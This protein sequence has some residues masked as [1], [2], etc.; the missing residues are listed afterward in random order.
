MTIGARARGMP[1]PSGAALGASHPALLVAEYRARRGGPSTFEQRKK[2]GTLN[3]RA[4]RRS[5][6]PWSS[7]GRVRAVQASQRP[8]GDYREAHPSDPDRPRRRITTL[9]QLLC[10]S[11]LRRPMAVVLAVSMGSSSAAAFC[12][13]RA[14]QRRLALGG[15]EGAGS[16]GRMDAREDWT[17]HSAAHAFP[18][19]ACAQVGN[20]V[21]T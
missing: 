12:T 3:A 10:L 15:T 19:A 16:R 9:R 4:K 7:Y 1:R 21:E 20:Q 14:V 11:S 13:G 18:D 6:D 5:I 2:S 8:A 17:S